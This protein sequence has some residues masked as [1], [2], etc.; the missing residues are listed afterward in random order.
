MS[1]W[2]GNAVFALVIVPAVLVVLEQVREPIRQ[3]GAYAKDITTSVST[4]APHLDALQELGQR[5]DLVRQ[6][7]AE[8]DRYVRALDNI[9]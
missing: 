3:I 7:N 2:I 1:L 6:V 9:R 8:M 4:F 5:R